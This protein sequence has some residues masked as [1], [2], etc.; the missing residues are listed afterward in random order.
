MN[1][2]NAIELVKQGKKLRKRGGREAKAPCRPFGFCRVGRHL[3]S[4]GLSNLE[5]PLS[6]GGGRPLLCRSGRP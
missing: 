4:A 3:F 6:D 1:F 2:G 5:T